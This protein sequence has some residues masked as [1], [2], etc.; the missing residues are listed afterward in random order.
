MMTAESFPAD[1]FEER[2]L[3]QCHP[4][5]LGEFVWTAMDYLGESGIG[6]WSYGEPKQATQLNQ[7]KGILRSYI[8]QDGSRRQKSNAAISKGPAPEPHGSGIS[9]ACSLLWRS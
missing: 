5:I 8:G 9:M 3:V 1:A 6:A 4:C 7:L 2:E